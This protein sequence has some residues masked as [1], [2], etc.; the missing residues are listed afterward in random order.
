MLEPSHPLTPLVAVLERAEAD[1]SD[2]EPLTTLAEL[3][4][5]RLQQ[6]VLL[7][8][9]LL[10]DDEQRELLRRLQPLGLGGVPSRH[11]AAHR[12]GRLMM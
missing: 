1:P 7:A 10:F 5:S 11:R 6:L 2:L 8:A 4:A 12:A 9:G 3:G